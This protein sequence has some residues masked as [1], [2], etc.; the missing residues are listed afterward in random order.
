MISDLCNRRRRWTMSIPARPDHDPDL[1]IGDGLTAGR[2]A[3]DLLEKVTA[4]R[5]HLLRRLLNAQ[6]DCPNCENREWGRPATLDAEG[7]QVLDRSRRKCSNCCHIRPNPEACQCRHKWI[8]EEDG[9]PYCD[10]STTL[11]EVHP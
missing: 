5:D 11:C 6:A 4:Q 7:L 2:E 8:T 9:Q 1:V 10:I 3:E